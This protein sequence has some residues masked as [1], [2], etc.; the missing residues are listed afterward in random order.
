VLPSDASVTL[1]Q[2]PNTR[3]EYRIGAG[4]DLVG[5]LSSLTGG[6]A[7]NAAQTAPKPTNTQSGNSPAA[8]DKNNP[9]PN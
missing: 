5:L 2:M 7:K 9:P 6:G 8:P 4:V 3:D 1:I